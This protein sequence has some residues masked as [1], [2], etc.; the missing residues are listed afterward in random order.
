MPLVYLDNC[1]LQ[2][3]LDDRTQF[4]VH[5]EADAVSAIIAAV[6]AGRLQLVTSVPLRA[7]SGAA[8]DTTRRDFA[9]EALAL[10]EVD[11]SL[12]DEVEEQARRFEELGM[13]PLDALHVASAMAVEANYF[14]TTDDRLLKKARTA[15]TGHHQN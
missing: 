2:R 13:K 3:P 5:T 7:E 10:A 15:N 4:R 9:E 11:A 14:C 12:S 8:T 6:E 1:A